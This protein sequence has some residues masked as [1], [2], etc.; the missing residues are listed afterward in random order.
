MSEHVARHLEWCAQRNLR[1]SYIT[2][3]RQ[4]L[5]LLERTLGKPIETAT[6]DDL[7]LWYAD[8]ATRIEPAA[9]GRYLSHASNFYRWM[10]RSRLR[11]DD[12]TVRLM[13]PRLQRRLPRPISDRDL[14]P[15]LLNAPDRVR[16]WML[17]GLLAGL[18]ACEIANLRGEDINWDLNMIVIVEGKGGKQRLVPLHPEVAAELDDL[19]RQGW[20]FP[21]W[22]HPK[23]PMR[24]WNVSHGVNFFLHSIGVEA[25]FHQFRH[26][27]AT[28]VFAATKDLRLTQ[29]LL[30]HAD[31]RTTAGYA[32]WDRSAATAA[33]EQLKI[34]CL[35]LPV[36]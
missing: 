18:R 8:L 9:R 27:F 21:H 35:G 6:A 28:D 10:V 30:G 12:P 13:Q 23:R 20:L 33:I 16:P 36:D 26:R 17:L 32:A 19:P 11:D 15:A 25:T 1:P 14:I 3:R 34:P 29:E 24:P 7:E 4:Q 31:P 5:A 2:V 22:D